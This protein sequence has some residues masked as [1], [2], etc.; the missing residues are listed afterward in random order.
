MLLKVF[1]DCCICFA[2][3][4]SGPVKFAIPLLLPALICGV[5]ACVATVCDQKGWDALRRIS[6]ALPFACLLLADGVGQMLILAAPAVYTAVVI[7]RGELHLEYSG[8]RHF[9]IRSLM[10]LGL[11]Y[12]V[13]NVW[14][15]LTQIANEAVLQLDTA[16]ILRYGLVHL[17]CGV[18]LQRQLRLGVGY[19]AEGGRR[20]MTM[21]LTTTA[22]IVVGFLAAEPFLRQSLGAI[23]R[24]ILSLVLVPFGLLLDLAGKLIGRLVKSDSDKE[25]YEEFIDYI[26]NIGLGGAERPGQSGMPGEETVL[27]TTA[28][29]AVLAGIFVLVAAILLLR[30]FYKNRGEMVPSDLTSRVVTSQKKKKAATFSNR[31]RVRQIYRDFLRAEKDL[32]M[33]LSKS[34]TS[35]TVLARIHSRTDRSSAE[36]LRCVYLEARYDD[37]KQITREQVEAAKRA[38]RNTRKAKTE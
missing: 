33:K 12:I 37:R 7:L 8:Y 4:G 9:F 5:A 26:E 25:T 16:V 34:D 17:L 11:V 35:G 13:A 18:V 19:R 29:W 27:N 22:A 1:S 24:E 10:L 30:S 31:S 2:I 15:F 14:L 36:A 6:A 21:L 38:L 20:Q 32:G 28:I 23:L 3:L